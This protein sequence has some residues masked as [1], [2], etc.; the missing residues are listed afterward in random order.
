MNKKFTRALA[1]L[2]VF[3]MLGMIFPVA[4]LA[5]VSADEATAQAN[6]SAD[7]IDPDTM[8]IDDVFIQDETTADAAADTVTDTDVAD[9][10]LTEDTLD[11]DA[12]VV[13]TEG[14]PVE[15]AGDEAAEETEAVTEEEES[16]DA[17]LEAQAEEASVAVY[18]L[19]NRFTNEHLYTTDVNEKN[20]LYEKNGWGYEGVCWYAPTT[21]T[22][23]YRLYNANQQNHLYTTDANE[24]K[25]LTSKYG[26]TK[27]NGGNAV[28]YSGGSVPVYR[29]YN[30]SLSGMHHL[31]TD[32]NEYT[33]LSK[34]GWKGEGVV[35]YATKVGSP[36]ATKYKNELKSIAIYRLF[37]PNTNEHLYTTSAN[38]KDTLYNIG[39]GY[40]GIAWY[41]A[42]GGTPVYRLYNT[43]SKMH[44]YTTDVN[45]VKTLT[46]TNTG[47]RKDNNGNAVF[48]SYGNINVYRLY[49]K[50]TG[51]HHWTTDANEYNAL[52]KAGWKQEGVKFKGYK[53]G[54]T[55]ATQY[56][57]QP[58]SFAF[59]PPEAN[60][61]CISISTQTMAVFKNGK[62]TMKTDV[63]TGNKGTYD[64]PTGNFVI[65]EKSRNVTLMPYGSY[66][67]FWMPFYLDYGIHDANGWRSQYGGSIYNG[68]GSHGCV[69]TPYQNAKY[70]WDNCPVGTRV[71]IRA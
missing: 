55:V 9:S 64:T 44:L 68:N 15:T 45:E 22:P 21:G 53:A 37:N 39:W 61:I 17:L 35:L 25:T 42:D 14:T 41:A 19:Y 12:T 3:V 18:R 69:N 51:T 2:L 36:T 40:E 6:L 52:P 16:D 57:V 46:T 66:V 56:K 63:V 59:Q 48:Y 29:V 27:D 47:W 38:E 31:T 62:M 43:R 58:A 23:V 24:V 28:F 49:N 4:S 67:N 30:K 32:K 54:K 26:W 10:D 50:K 8:S 7:T 34:S 13:E 11:Q 33:T 5:E 1:A 60:C 70:I 71:Y 65:Y 20:T